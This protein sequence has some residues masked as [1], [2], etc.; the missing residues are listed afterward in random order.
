MKQAKVLVVLSVIIVSILAVSVVLALFSSDVQK[1]SV[2]DN[3]SD[4]LAQVTAGGTPVGPWPQPTD[5]TW[6]GPQWPAN[7]VT[8]ESR[9][10]P[11]I[12]KSFA[13]ITWPAL[14]DGQVLHILQPTQLE[15]VSPSRVVHHPA[16]LNHRSFAT[17]TA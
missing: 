2:G 16:Q 5:P 15:R 17:N 13:S 10:W 11:A 14:H 12:H 1:F 8:A 6:R 7:H 9:K 3:R 4:Q